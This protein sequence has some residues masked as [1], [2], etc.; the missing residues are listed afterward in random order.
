MSYVLDEVEGFV[1]IIADK[2]DFL[3]GASIIGPKA[4][5]L[6]HVL[7]LALNNRMKLAQVRDTIFAHPTISEA[8]SD[9]L[10]H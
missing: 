5:E 6:I 9:A 7:T 3:L 10:L 1:K 4:S 8:I 2:D